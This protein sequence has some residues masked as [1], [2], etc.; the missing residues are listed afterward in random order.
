MNGRNCNHLSHLLLE[1]DVPV[2]RHPKPHCVLAE[3][4]WETLPKWVHKCDELH[5]TFET[6]YLCHIFC[7][8]DLPL[9]V[10]TYLKRKNK[11]ISS[12]V[13]ETINL[14]NSVICNWEI[15]W[16]IPPTISIFPLEEWFCCSFAP[17]PYFGCLIATISIE[18]MLQVS[19][20][21]D[22]YAVDCH[23]H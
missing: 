15:M 7:I 6:H 12:T 18:G 8:V 21:N 16:K 19:E 3:T 1:V 13:K 22:N 14:I 23:C 20:Q 17:F 2:E 9:K 10:V 5:T 11:D 4:F